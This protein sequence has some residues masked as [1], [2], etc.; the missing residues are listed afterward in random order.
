ML[1]VA[2]LLYGDS[3]HII[4]GDYLRVNSMLPQGVNPDGTMLMVYGALEGSGLGY[5]LKACT[6]TYRPGASFFGA[7]FSQNYAKTL[8]EG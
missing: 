3:L 6:A 8:N 5:I 1:Q 2:R 4:N 7:C